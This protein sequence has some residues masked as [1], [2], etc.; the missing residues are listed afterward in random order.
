MR[1]TDPR[2]ESD[3]EALKNDIHRLRGDWTEMVDSVASCSRNM[4][5]RSRNRLRET[6]AE[7]EGRARERLR[8]TGDVLR[9]RG[10][11]AMS[12]WRGGVGHRPI[13]SIAI[14][15]AA[16]VLLASLIERRRR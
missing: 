10:R 8:D 5:M 7:L 4:V 1:M 15:F 12:S 3:I 14:A 11:G 9:D 16:G 13:T 6:M 2:I